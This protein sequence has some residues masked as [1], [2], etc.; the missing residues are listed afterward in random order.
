VTAPGVDLVDRRIVGAART[1][2]R[3]GPGRPAL[4]REQESEQG[5]P[6]A[7]YQ[8]PASSSSPPSSSPSA[9]G[10]SPE[11]PA[12][13]SSPGGL[14]DAPPFSHAATNVPKEIA[15]AAAAIRTEI[16]VEVDMRARGYRNPL[17]ADAAHSFA[18][19]AAL[20]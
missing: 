15:S 13:S 7:H 20:R 17:R 18:V 16:G 12:A 19:A 1:R 10:S 6:G 9:S 4:A 2:R 3:R 5:Q 14:L 8:P 11:S